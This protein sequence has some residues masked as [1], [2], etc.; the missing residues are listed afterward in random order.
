MRI[1]LSNKIAFVTG[2][3]G[4]LG[5]V[6]VQQ[7]RGMRRRRCHLLPEQWNERGGTEARILRRWENEQ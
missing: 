1:D 6:M 5:R 3:A 2:G 4:Q 7:A